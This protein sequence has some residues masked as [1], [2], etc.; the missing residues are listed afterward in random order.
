MVDRYDPE[1]MA[2]DH[3]CICMAECPE[4]DWVRYGAYAELERKLEQWRHGSNSVT[5]ISLESRAEKVMSLIEQFGGID[6]DHHKQWVIDQILRVLTGSGYG[7]WVA[8]Y[9][10]GEDGPD[11]YAWDVGIAP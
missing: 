1:M 6:G 7:A 11:S 3:P 2:G 10:N 5:A 4:G 9:C 8:A